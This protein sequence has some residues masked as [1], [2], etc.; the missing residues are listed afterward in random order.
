MAKVDADRNLLFGVLALQLELIDARQFADA[1]SGWAARKEIALADLLVERGWLAQSDR[2]EVDRLLE[3]KLSRHAGNVHASLA[4][5]ADHRIKGA[6]AGLDDPE[7][8]RTIDSLSR[9]DRDSAMSTI[10]YAPESHEK[11]RLTRLHAKGGLGQI[12]LARD[13]ELGREVALKELRPERAGDPV[14]SARFFE[15]ARVTGQLEHPNIVPVYELVKPEDGRRPF[16]TM[17]FVQG[18]TLTEAARSYHEARAAGRTGPLDLRA[19]LNALV[20]VC[21]AVAYAHSRGVLHR[22]L[23][24]S[25]VVLGD[26]GEVILLDWGLAKLIHRAEETVTPSI[27]A[28][29]SDS[30]DD[31]IQGQALGTPACMAPE[32]AEGR[33]KAIDRRSDVYG[34]GA[35][36]FEILTGRA[37]FVGDSVTEVLRQVKHDPPA[38]PR[39]L[40]PDAP[41][42]LEAV[43]LK[44]LA[45][46]PIARYSSALELAAEIEHYLADEPVKAYREP[47][48]RRLERWARRHRPLVAG[49]AVL[50]VT[51]STALAV[52]NVLVR[53]ERDLTEAARRQAETNFSQARGTVKDLVQRA[54]DH[55]LESAPRSEDVRLDLAD[56]AHMVTLYQLATR[57]ADRALRIDAGLDLERVADLQIMVGRIDQALGEAS[58]AVHLLIDNRPPDAAIN[59]YS[60]GPAE[61]L[62]VEDGQDAERV[63][64]LARAMK[65]VGRALK[66]QGRMRETEAY[67]RR[68][69][70]FLD[71][72]GCLGQSSAPTERRNAVR[73]LSHLALL[74][75]E[76]G[77]NEQARETIA[78]ASALRDPTER[79]DTII[80]IHRVQGVI[81]NALG[82]KA[83]AEQVL[84]EAVRIGRAIV[85]ENRDLVGRRQELA[86][87]LTA[88]GELLAADPARTEDA[89]SAFNEALGLAEVLAADFRRTVDHPRLL[90]DILHARGLT[91]AGAGRPNEAEAD[92]RAALKHAESIST[93]PLDRAVTTQVRGDL[94]RVVRDRGRIS[95]A[96]E[97]LNRAVRDGEAIARECPDFLSVKQAL[98]ANRTEL[99]RLDQPH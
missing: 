9:P 96:R 46:D 18:R 62:R 88:H 17:R 69:I 32:Q 66:Y 15:E 90:A 60:L 72:A 5:V 79:S 40:N 43:C 14:V 56:R 23:K 21:N 85:N 91:R 29:Q 26:F 37:P 20:E 78:R 64:A 2:V 34:L 1:C 55:A 12:W 44:A 31:T 57:P 73:T 71:Q 22:D 7:V 70:E 47:W 80:R 36:L 33:L 10:G 76:Q 68:A 97:L 51:A 87:A 24:G 13:G 89:E 98:T 94:A 11:Y 8:L 4:E 61:A 3:R 67:F 83:G 75:H 16:Y 25:N 93:N 28:G 49:T 38:R 63:Q 19:L 77:R 92:L 54:V 27:E 39:S 59:D 42:A 30:R 35:I 81:L 41:A 74:Q 53:R 45:K 65:T 86:D 99:K 95:E 82:D 52:N 84:G 48:P 6:L 50:L 58:R